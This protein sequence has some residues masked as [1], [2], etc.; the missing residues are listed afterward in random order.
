MGWNFFIIRGISVISVLKF[1]KVKK[2]G[3]IPITLELFFER[4]I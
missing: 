4:G 1:I 2:A 3:F